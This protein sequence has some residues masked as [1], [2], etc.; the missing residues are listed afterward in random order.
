MHKFLSIAALLLSSVASAN[1]VAP[2][3]EAQDGDRLLAVVESFEIKPNNKGLS[4][5]SVVTFW[6]SSPEK[7]IFWAM[8]ATSCARGAG[9]IIAGDPKTGKMERYFWTAGG[10]RIYD[11]VAVQLCTAKRRI[12]DSETDAETEQDPGESV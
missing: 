12:E 4:V 8:D 10:K 11:G 7:L 1:T 3:A 5:A 2:I 6:A 9:E